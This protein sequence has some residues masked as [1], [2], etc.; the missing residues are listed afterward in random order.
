MIVGVIVV[1]EGIVSGGI[2]ISSTILI[3]VYESRLEAVLRC[4]KK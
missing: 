1:Y 4:V 3:G 2:S